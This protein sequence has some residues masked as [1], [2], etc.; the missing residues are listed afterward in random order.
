[1]IP[2]RL[3]IPSDQLSTLDYTLVYFLVVDALKLHNASSW[4]AIHHN[5]RH[6]LTLFLELLLPTCCYPLIISL[7][8]IRLFFSLFFLLIL[9]SS[10]YSVLLSAPSYIVI[11]AATTYS[12]YSYNEF[13]IVF[14]SFSIIQIHKYLLLPVVYAHSITLI[15]SLLLS[16]YHRCF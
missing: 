12:L 14:S 3:V 13:S 1:M 9:S 15:I 16:L 8:G 11:G 10:V 4:S 5:V 6:P 2:R 7:N